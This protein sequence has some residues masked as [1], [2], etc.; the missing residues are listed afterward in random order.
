MAIVYRLVPL[1]FWGYEPVGQ[2]VPGDCDCRSEDHAEPSD[3]NVGSD[4]KA[5]L[6]VTIDGFA[7]LF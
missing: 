2:M 5:D 4:E 3:N 6:T 1:C 7:W